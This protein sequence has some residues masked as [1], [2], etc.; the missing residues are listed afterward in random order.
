ME[1]AKHYIH[2]LERYAQGLH[3]GAE[4]TQFLNWFDHLD[5]EVAELVME[6]YAQISAKYESDQTLF[7]P[8]KS[9]IN[10]IE[11]RLDELSEHKNGDMSE[12]RFRLGFLRYAAAAI[13]VLAGTFAYFT[14]SRKKTPEVTTVKT[15]SNDA[16]PGS[17]KAILTLADGSDII[18][19]DAHNGEIAVQ[20][21]IRITKTADGKLIY[22]TEKITGNTDGSSPR[23]FNTIT[24]PKAG[25]FKVNLPDGTRV[26]LNSL[27]SIRF[28]ASFNGPVRTVDITGEVYFE[29]AQLQKNIN[30][31]MQKVPFHVSSADQVVE[32]LGTHF[33]INS[34]QDESATKTTLL[35]GSVRV[36]AAKKDKNVKSEVRLRPG[37]Q[38]LVPAR[39]K[40]QPI[41]VAG[42]TV[43]SVDSEEAVAWK[44]GYFR[45][46][47]ANIQDVMRQ[48]ARWY[49]IEVS[50]EGDFSS[51]QFTGFV[52]RN[53]RMSNVLKILQE[54][55]GVKFSIKGKKVE[56]TKAE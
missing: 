2:F 29:V 48:L 40:S 9:L 17:S 19:D 30:G 38:A 7:P 6:Q 52:S 49:D 24:T 46:K 44:E 32:V 16:V 56:V 28:P 37:E 11:Q 21:G 42:I 55:G 8:Q 15:I 45:F 22:S 36:L 1:D 43:R 5:P 34:Y 53:I 18:L 25:Q 31:K 35:E 26:W 23:V 4:H 51:E 12:T 33:N 27:S 50:Y 13:L 39:I 41:S 47:D 14:L 20:E 10:S 3:S 54:G